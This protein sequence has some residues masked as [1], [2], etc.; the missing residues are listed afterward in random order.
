[1]ATTARRVK[2][3]K[4]KFAV[5]KAFPVTEGC[6]SIETER[7]YKWHFER[8]KKWLPLREVAVEND[9]DLLHIGRETIEHE[10]IQY[11]K[12]LKSLKLSRSTIAIAIAAIAHFCKVNNIW[13]NKERL[14]QFLPEDE[15]YHE[16]REYRR[17]EIEKLLRESDPRFRTVFLLLA[18]TGM[19]I[20]AIPELQIG[21]LIAWP[22]PTDDPKPQKVYQI[23][24]YNRSKRH[25]YYTFCTPECTT[26]ID[27]YLA[28]RKKNTKEDIS[29]KSHPLIREQFPLFNKRIDASIPKSIT[30]SSLQHLVASIVKHAGLD[31]TADERML[32][33]GFRKFCMTM[34]IKARINSE[35]RTYLIGHKLSRGLLKQYDK[36]SEQDRLFEWSKAINYLTIETDS[37]HLQRE[38]RVYRD[39]YAKRIQ[40]LESQIAI[41][42]RKMNDRQRKRMGLND[43]ISVVE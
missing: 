6:K 14:S 26:A 3:S 16:D 12:Y 30:K 20:G 21:D 34:M 35:V 42:Q 17:D 9:D 11:M 19:R 15:N 8:F 41:M 33:H 38:L 37:F 18:S 25:R 22:L 29:Q 1:M 39:E 2:H 40:G 7:Q 36:S 24:V 27:E 28:F 32:T 5:K 43:G 10:T 31:T 4:Q 23:W 13:L